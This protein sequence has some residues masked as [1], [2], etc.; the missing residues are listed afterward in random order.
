MTRWLF[1]KRRFDWPRARGHDLHTF[2]MMQALAAAG[3][4]VSVLTLEPSAPRALDGIAFAKRY[5]PSADA[6][7]AASAGAATARELLA[8]APGELLSP[9]ARR[10]LAVAA[11][12][13]AAPEISYL[14]RKFQSYWGVPPEAV[15]RVTAA[16]A[17]CGADVV[18][19]CGMGELPLLAGVGDRKRVWYAADEWVWHHLS[20]LRPTQPSTWKHLKEAGYNWLCQRAYRPWLDRVWVVTPADA[21][22]FRRIDGYTKLDVIPN[23][24][25]AAG[26]APGPEPQE[27]ATCAFWGRLDYG[28]NLQALSWFCDR[29]WPAIIERVPAARFRVYG[30]QPVPAAVALGRRPGVELTADLPDLRPAVR[31]NQVAVMPFVSG[32]G[33]KNKVLE[34]AALGLPVVASERAV[35]GLSGDPPFL[36]PRTPA[37]WADAVVNL[38]ADPARR[39]A[40]GAAARSWVV[41]THTWAAAA[42]TAAEGVAT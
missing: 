38:W 18:V 41:R 15:A 35:L 16:A 7:G 33:I 1:V 20:Q 12:K 17:D 27:E 23:G 6:A 40:A 14:Q 13:D 36:M 19:A 26:F 29:V 31:G 30:F 5:E 42:R 4:A 9:P 11:P 24:V 34:A 39:T 8:G 21:H 2:G 10:S 28:P 37:A 22:M 32:G 3:H 25:D